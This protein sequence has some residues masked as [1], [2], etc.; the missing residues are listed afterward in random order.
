MCCDST[1]TYCHK[2]DVY[3]G[4]QAKTKHGLGYSVVKDMTSEL[5]GSNRQVFFDNFFTS[6][7]L[8]EGLQQED[9]LYSCGTV[10][11]NRIGF[12]AELKK[13]HDL[14]QRGQ[15]RV[16]QKSDTP[17]VAS[18]WKDSSYVHTLSTLPDSTKVVPGQRQRGAKVV[19]VEMPHSVAQ[20][21]W[22]ISGMDLHNHAGVLWG[23]AQLSQVVKVPQLLHVELLC[24]KCLS[25][26]QSSQPQEDIGEEVSPPG[27]PW[28]AGERAH[29]RLHQQEEAILSNEAKTSWHWEHS[30]LFPWVPPWEEETLCAVRIQRRAKGVCVWMF[31]VWREPMQ[32]GM[33]CPVP[34]WHRHWCVEHNK[35]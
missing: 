25:A 26:L 29:R 27:L 20:Y 22:Y 3:L 18:V 7:H 5:R 34:H 24:H 16:L 10:W 15:M 9:S 23:W 6:V 19:P 33:P 35:P 4:K 11:T 12:P 14:R 1:N 17:L 8:V 30:S 31:Y 21:N 13:P 32:E 28:G 2:F